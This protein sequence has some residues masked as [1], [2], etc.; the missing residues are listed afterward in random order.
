MVY[1][2][3]MRR[4]NDKSYIWTN[5]LA[6][7]AG[8]F[9]ADG[10]LLNDNRHLNI[11][12][13]DIEIIEYLQK[14][15]GKKWKIQTKTGQFMTSAYY[16]QFSDTALYDFFNCAGITPKKSL[17][18]ASVA[19]P[20]K[21]YAHFLRGYFD[22]DGTIWG[23]KDPRWP[24]SFMYYSGFTSGSEIFLRWINLQNERLFGTTRVAIKQGVR[25]KVLSYAKKDSL[26]LFQAMYRSVDIEK[27]YYLRRKYKKFIDFLSNDPYY[28]AEDAQVL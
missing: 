19:V 7:L 26:R 14:I 18:I 20:D 13:K 6:Y 5:E 28:I 27:G 9:A 15:L 10:C 12:S 21:F 4:Y 1:T 3:Y 17:T 23:Y 22:G 2:I 8:L 11:T 24:N 25:S 16:V